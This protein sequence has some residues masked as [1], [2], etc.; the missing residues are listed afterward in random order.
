MKPTL[1]LTAVVLLV[2]A[3]GPGPDRIV[4]LDIEGTHCTACEPAIAQMLT[5][6]EGVRSATVSHAAKEAVV[7][8]AGDVDP[9]DLVAAVVGYQASVREVKVAPPSE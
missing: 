2:V 8:C 6:V 1:A 3:C 7:V 9:A 5:G 4:V